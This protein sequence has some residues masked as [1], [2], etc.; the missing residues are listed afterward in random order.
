MTLKLVTMTNG[1]VICDVEKVKKIVPIGAAGY[2]EHH[3]A[4]TSFQDKA[5]VLRQVN[6]CLIEES[7]FKFD[8]QNQWGKCETSTQSTSN[9]AFTCV[10]FGSIP[11]ILLKFSA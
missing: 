8:K 3:S 10:L 1:K 5:K 2:Q 6:F 4:E 7:V 11:F 9:T